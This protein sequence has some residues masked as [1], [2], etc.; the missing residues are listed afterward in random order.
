[1]N[2]NAMLSAEQRDQ[3]AKVPTAT[4]CSVLSK[5]GVTNV[6]IRRARPLP[7]QSS[8]RVVGSAYTLRFAPSRTGLNLTLNTRTAIESMPEGVVVIADSSGID[9]V[10]LVGDV[11][12]LRMHQL[13]VRGLVT[14][15][16]VRDAEG[17]RDSGLPVWCAGPSAPLPGDGVLL[18]GMQE[19][20]NCGGVTV[21][22]YDALVCDADGA[23]V[24]PRELVSKVLEQAQATERFEQWVMLEVKSG[25]PLPGLYPPDDE[26]KRR[27]DLWLKEQQ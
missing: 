10:G 21:C 22:P 8:M 19:I 3:L 14:D 17:I 20:I 18:V 26:S 5:L 23:V 25:T 13:G 7:G 12:G 1:M 4:L 2:S 24:I 15:G 16:A 9:D 27:Y 11:L 6:W